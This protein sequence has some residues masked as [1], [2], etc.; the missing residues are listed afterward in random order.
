MFKQVDTVR[1]AY[2][3]SVADNVQA[4]GTSNK[5]SPNSL[6]TTSRNDYEDDCN[7]KLQLSSNRASANQIAKEEREEKCA[8]DEE[9][10]E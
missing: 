2:S 4:Y 1:D 3:N 7:S 6:K 8:E 10:V 9:E 5:L